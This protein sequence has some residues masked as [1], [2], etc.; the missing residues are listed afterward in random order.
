MK[1]C[2]EC[3][4]DYYDDTLLYCLDDGNALL[5]GPASGS[6]SEPPVSGGGQSD[7]PRTAILHET[8]PPAEARTQAQIPTT[9]KTAV[10]RATEAE[11]R[12]NLRDSTERQSLSAN[13]AAKPLAVVG[14]VILLLVGGFAAYLYLPAG[15]NAQINS[16]AVL[17]FENTSGI[18][19]SEYLSDGIAES[20]IYRLSQIPDLK[21]SP[22]SSVF[23]YK[24]KDI[25][26]EKVGGELGVDAVMSGR[27]IQR[28]D[29]LTIS[30]CAKQEDAMGRTV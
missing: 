8:A 29:N 5:D 6:Q 21:V 20:V 24:G 3:R 16:I 11:P 7:E 26:V 14:I 22:R 28:G 19:D 13:R 18:A 2:P 1:R 10:L 4:R 12:E 9:E 25:D 15:G 27:M 17:P 30:V 23:R